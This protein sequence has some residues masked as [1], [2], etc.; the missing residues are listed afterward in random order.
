MSDT[1]SLSNCEWKEFKFAEI[2]D[3]IGGL[4]RANKR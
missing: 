4:S 1:M 2:I 3:L